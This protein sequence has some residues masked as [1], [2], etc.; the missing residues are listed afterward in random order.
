MSRKFRAL[1]LLSVLAAI[2]FAGTNTFAVS[3]AEI[4][5][6]ISAASSGTPADPGVPSANVGQK[7]TIVGTGLVAST[8]V[9]FPTLSASGVAS[10]RTVFPSRV[11]TLGG[12]SA[13]EVI[14]PDD[15]V[16]GGVAV[17]GGASSPTLQIVPTIVHIAANS[18]TF[19]A[20]SSF[21]IFGSG[22]PEGAL[23]VHFGL[24]SVVDFSPTVS[25]DIFNASLNSAFNRST[26]DGITL[27]LPASPDVGPISVET[28]GGH[29]LHS[30]SLLRR[31]T[32][33]R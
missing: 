26:N 15:A 31:L 29:P 13:I 23:T 12:D 6:I 2:V 21:Q 8:Q 3:A 11:F 16:T 20:G 32:L 28:A 33:R 19:S 24:A 4:S 5:A 18:N 17:A 7:I 14:V 25:P 30:Q 1:I 10:T 22:F 27:S 9:V